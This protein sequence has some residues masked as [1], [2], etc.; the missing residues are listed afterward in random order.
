MRHAFRPA[1]GAFCGRFPCGKT[2]SWHEG[3]NLPVFAANGLAG[4]I[5]VSHSGRNVRKS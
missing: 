2:P 4:K 3:V 1:K 5:M